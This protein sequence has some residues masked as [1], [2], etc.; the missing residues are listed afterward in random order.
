MFTSSNKILKVPEALISID[1]FKKST[2]LY[3][4]CS[5]KKTSHT[6]IYFA[7]CSFVLHKFVSR[8]FF[9]K[10]NFL[11]LLKIFI[12]LVLLLKSNKNYCTNFFFVKIF[13]TFV[14]LV[15]I[16]IAEYSLFLCHLKSVFIHDDRE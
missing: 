14:R 2:K 4:L 13:V 8:Q 1:N 12:L 16:T 10:P 9:T 5:S 7:K 3:K 15:N 6:T 11:H